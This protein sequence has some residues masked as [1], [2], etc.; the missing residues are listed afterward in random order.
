MSAD[1]LRQQAHG[2]PPL[3]ARLAPWMRALLADPAEVGRLID[4]YG[5]PVNVHNF[6]ALADNAQEMISAGARHGVPVHVFVARKANKTLELVDE[7]RRLGHGID[8]GSDRELAQVLDRGMP[9]ER[10]ILTAAIKPEPLLRRALAAEVPISVDNLDEA[11]LLRRLARETGSTRVASAEDTGHAAPMVLRLAPPPS[12]LI[13]PTRFGELADTWLQDLAAHPPRAHGLAVVGVH[14][15]LHGYDAPARTAAL[16]DAIRL[17]DALRERGE[18]VRFIDMGGGVPM[19]YLE[20][21]EQWEEFWRSHRAAIAAGTPTQT[22]RND[23]LGVRRDSDGSAVGAPDMYPYFQHLTRG[24]W[25]EQVLTGEVTP[26]VS[27]A[28]ALRERDLALHCEPGRAMLDGCGMTLARVAQRTHTSDGVPLVGL[29]MNRT[30]CRSTSADFL[31]DPILVRCGTDDAPHQH[32][33]AA[34][35]APTFGDGGAFLV[36][37]Y[38]IEA[39]LILRRRIAFPQGVQVGDVI[40]LPNTAGYLMHILESASHQIPLAS[41]V[42]RRRDSWVRDDID[43]QP[44]AHH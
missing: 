15:H 20:S 7:A 27:A 24:A 26:G 23:G 28:A 43:A 11:H 9:A 25:L 38:C 29:E 16:A 32:E 3:D 2:T 12:D 40:A 30:Q 44:V 39:E 13:A 18:P 34:E 6:T 21:A 31:V 35:V 41:N 5:S 10:I 42:V 19:R 14:F 22:W 8:V 36:G 1:P 37:A 17:V 4:R 33:T